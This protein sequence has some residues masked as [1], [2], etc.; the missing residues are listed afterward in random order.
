MVLCLAMRSAALRAAI[1]ATACIALGAGA[2]LLFQSEQ[3]IAQLTVSLRTFDQRARE[4]ADALIDA[5]VAQQAYVAAGQGIG[6]WMPK[7]TS[8]TEAANAA[9]AT[10]RESASAPAQ[11]LLEQ[12]AA[13]AGEFGAIEQR[14][15]EYLKT[16]QLLMAGDVIFTEGGETAA[17][18]ARLVEAARQ[19]EHQAYD[20]ATAA[21]RKEEATIA[22]AATGIAALAVLLLVPRGRREATPDA[23][24]EPA[25]SIARAVPVRAQPQPA[26]AM[27]TPS[28][29][30]SAAAT[31]KQAAALATDLGRVRDADDLR[32]ALGRAADA[33]DASGVMV[34]LGSPAGGDLRVVLAHG[35]P[36][37]VLARIPPVPRSADN[38][39]AAAYRSAALQI[40]LAR[41]GRANGAVVAPILAPEGCIGAVSAE[42][43]HG[44]ETSDGVQAM[45][46]IAAAQLAG[47]LAQAPAEPVAQPRAAQR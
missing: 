9:I 26:A 40:V 43:R 6:F 27:P 41:P 42:I 44:G 16:S 5:R 39:A 11:P 10:L 33:M 1:G 29:S 47:V 21:L 3:R 22:A 20:G 18:A 32:R 34:W 46:E 24:A 25:P 13:A 2:I 38:A 17:S 12:A 37:D 30:S 8:T 23:V 4:A 31:F 28:T 45:A 15:R 36:S 7:V 19:A 35:Y 14:V